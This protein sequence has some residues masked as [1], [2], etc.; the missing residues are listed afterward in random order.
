MR[1][2]IRL[3]ESELQNIIEESVRRVIAENMED[4]FNRRDVWNGIKGIGR[5][6]NKRAISPAKQ[7]TRK[8]GEKLQQGINGA[9]DTIVGTYDKAK[10]AVGDAYNDAK[11]AVSNTYDRAKKDINGY[12]QTFDQEM[13]ISQNTRYIDNA[14]KALQQLQKATNY[15]KNPLFGPDTDTAQSVAKTI[16]LLNSQIRANLN[17]RR[18]F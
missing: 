1:Q 3:T 8:F 13:N 4:E 11:T 10:G 12:K 16:S 17:K 18:E 14:I 6:F 15:G 9:K 2:Q 5:R 7:R